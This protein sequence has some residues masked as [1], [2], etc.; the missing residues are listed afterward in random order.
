MTARVWALNPR[1]VR[2][3][4]PPN[5]VFRECPEINVFLL[6]VCFFAQFSALSDLS[7]CVHLFVCIF[8]AQL[9]CT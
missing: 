8:F 7:G 5:V 1:C 3:P 6:F 2:R 4:V 9:D